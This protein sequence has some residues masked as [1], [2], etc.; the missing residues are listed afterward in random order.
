MVHEQAFNACMLSLSTLFLEQESLTTHQHLPEPKVLNHC[1]SLCE[2][3]SHLKFCPQILNTHCPIF[4]MFSKEM[5]F[6]LNMFWTRS[7][8]GSIHQCNHSLIVLKHSWVSCHSLQINLHMLL[9]LAYQLSCGQWV[10]HAL[11]QSNVFHLGSGKCNNLFAH[12]K[13]DPKNE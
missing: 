7:H 5:I 12:I 4:H 8:L 13:E 6:N 10:S 3:I 11:T 2:D 1:Q 9:Y